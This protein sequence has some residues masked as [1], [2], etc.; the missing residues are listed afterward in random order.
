[1]EFSHSTTPS[2]LNL[3]RSHKLSKFRFQ[4][5]KYFFPVYIC[6][7]FFFLDREKHCGG[8]APGFQVIHRNGVTVDNRLENLSLVPR[9][10]RLPSGGRQFVHRS[11]TSTAN[12]ICDDSGTTREHS[13]YWAAIQQLP[14][15]PGEEVNAP[16]NQ[17]IHSAYL[18]Y[19]MFDTV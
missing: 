13:L 4:Y 14:A 6:N 15:D 10:N 11:S 12:H 16:N 17:N 1:M 2:H 3:E 19:S 9:A 8:I 18:V 5:H 7:K